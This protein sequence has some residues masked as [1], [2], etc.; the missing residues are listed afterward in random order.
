[1]VYRNH[2]D[3]SVELVTPRLAAKWLA[4]NT[5]NRNLRPAQVNRYAHDMANGNWTFDSSAICFDEDGVLLN[6]QHRLSAVVKSGVPISFTIARDVPRDSMR[7]MDTGIA[8]GAG[9]ALKLLDGGPY[10]NAV[11]AAARFLL[12][13]ELGRLSNDSR[14]QQAAV[15]NSDIIDYAI[16]HPALTRSVAISER[17]R[18]QIEAPASVVAAAHAMISRVNNEEYSDRYVR[19]LATMVN[20]PEG[21]AVLAVNQRFRRIRIERQRVERRNYA[22]M[23]LKGWNYWATD[24]PAVRILSAP[25]DGQKFR[26]P[27]IAVW[28]KDDR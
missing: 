17:Y 16:E 13:V 3:V 26:L 9:D 24:T 22:Y 23:L 27:D 5:K 12:L 11:A 15:S 4:N 14:A 2:I 25:K 8:R 19:A 21:S 1:M 10:S 6:G 28:S 20:E 18:G 7:T